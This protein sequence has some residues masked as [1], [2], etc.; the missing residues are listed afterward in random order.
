[1]SFRPIAWLVLAALIVLGCGVLS[2]YRA[3]DAAP[4]SSYQAPF[5]NSVEQRAETLNELRAIRDL[6][7]EQNQLIREQNELLRGTLKVTVQGQSP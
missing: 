7:K 6:L 1:M 4:P 5:A 2:L 3:L